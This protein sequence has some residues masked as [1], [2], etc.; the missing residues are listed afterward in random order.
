MHVTSLPSEF[1][2][3]DL[4]PASDRFLRFLADSDQRLWQILPLNPVDNNMSYSPYGSFSVF[5]G[6]TLMIDPQDL[7]KR[8]TP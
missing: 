4:G 8:R 1:G 5:A 2:I 7:L 6:N 3:G